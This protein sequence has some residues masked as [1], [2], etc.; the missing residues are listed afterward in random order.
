MRAF[1]DVTCRVLQPQEVHCV[2]ML[3]TA[4]NSYITT[5]T[6]ITAN[7]NYN[8]HNFCY[9]NCAKYILH[10]MLFVRLLPLVCLACSD[11]DLLT[12]TRV[13]P[14]GRMANSHLLQDSRFMG[15]HVVL[16]FSDCICRR[17]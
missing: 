13:T 17:C 16:C 11:L 7:Y 6:T 9:C 5:S 15:T 4:A 1:N 3:L 12:T 8:Y 10:C 14:N 2:S